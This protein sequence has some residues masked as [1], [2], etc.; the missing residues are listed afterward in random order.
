MDTDM[1]KYRSHLPQLGKKVFLTDG[2]LETT[3]I[4]H[5][6]I[7]LPHFAAFDLMRTTEGQSSLRAY[8]EGYIQIAEAAGYG[9]ILESPTWRA[10]S[11]WGKSSAIRRKSW[12]RRTRH[13]SRCWP[14]CAANMRSRPFRWSS[15]AASDRAATAMIRAS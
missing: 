8:F 3:L 4:F 6:G 7:D 1:S 14:I 5:E 9:F 12:R 11:D 15:A 13:R 10:S 2:G